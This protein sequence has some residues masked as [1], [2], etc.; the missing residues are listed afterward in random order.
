MSISD[1]ASAYCSLSASDFFE[2]LGAFS[3]LLATS[4]MLG[5]AVAVIRRMMMMAIKPAEKL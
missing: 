4:V 2:A 1:V 5:I 3:G